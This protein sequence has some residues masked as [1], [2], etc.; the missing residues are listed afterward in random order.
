MCFYSLTYTEHSEDVDA[1]SLCWTQTQRN[2]LE[3][4]IAK[5]GKE[6][7][8]LIIKKD[9]HEIHPHSKLVLS[10][11]TEI[12]SVTADFVLSVFE[13]GLFV[14]VFGSQL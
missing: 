4:L 14:S 5:Q 13:L 9:D 11:V 12:L 7:K 10:T 6:A 1:G 3:I 8:T 2:A